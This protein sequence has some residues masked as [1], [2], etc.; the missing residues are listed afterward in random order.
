MEPV[1]A[2]GFLFPEMRFDN[3]EKMFTCL[4]PLMHI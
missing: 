2:N 3:R 1:S 4:D